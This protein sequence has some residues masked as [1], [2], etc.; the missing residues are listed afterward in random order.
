M[1][2]VSG[3]PS[4]LIVSTVQKMVWCT[5]SQCD[6]YRSYQHYTNVNTHDVS[7]RTPHQTMAPHIYPLV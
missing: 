5:I 4:Q 7:P 2:V 6:H 3:A 1:M